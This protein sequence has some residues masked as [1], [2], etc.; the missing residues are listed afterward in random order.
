MPDIKVDIVNRAKEDGVIVRE[1]IC[2]HK[3]VQPRGG[4]AHL[5]TRAVCRECRE[6]RNP[7]AVAEP[8]AARAD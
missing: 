1:L 6:A 3:Q 5:A 4:K 7:S 2:G 8:E